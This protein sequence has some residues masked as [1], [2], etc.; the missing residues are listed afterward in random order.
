MQYI[1]HEDRLQ[2]LQA[3][4]DLKD[5]LSTIHEC[6]DLY[7]S[8]VGKLEGLQYL[9]KRVMKFVPKKDYEGNPQFYRDYILEDEEQN[10]D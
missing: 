3:H 8:D 7:I 2:F 1:T 10:D 5:L 4:N 9:I 6:N